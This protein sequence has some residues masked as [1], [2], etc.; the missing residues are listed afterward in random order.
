LFDV[1][2]VRMFSKSRFPSIHSSIKGSSADFH[3]GGLRRES[4]PTI[5]DGN[6][7]AKKKA[8]FSGPDEGDADKRKTSKNENKAKS[9]K[10]VTT[11]IQSNSSNRRLNKAQFKHMKTIHQAYGQPLSSWGSRV[12]AD[13]DANSDDSC[14]IHDEDCF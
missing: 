4:E 7:K 8:H 11:Y 10:K 1:G 2:N 12:A 9:P 13:C 6:R 14:H 5:V 3:G